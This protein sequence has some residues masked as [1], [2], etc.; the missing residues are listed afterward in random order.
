M[1]ET[2]QIVRT[3]KKYKARI[4]SKIGDGDALIIGRRIE[5]LMQQK[6]KDEITPKELVEDAMHPRSPIHEYFEWSDKKAADAFRLYHARV[7][8]ASIEVEVQISGEEP[9]KTRAFFNIKS[10]NEEGEKESVYV[11]FDDVFSNEEMRSQIVEKAFG[12]LEGWKLRYRD[13]SEFSEIFRVI[14]ETEKVV[15]KK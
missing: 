9:R 2:K 5:E 3:R 8:L 7:L 11:K 10:I 1:A 12:E 13:Y 4:G 14:E 6:G 15:V